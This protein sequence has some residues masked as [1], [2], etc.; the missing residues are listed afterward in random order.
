M[1]QGSQDLDNQL[2]DFAD[3]TFSILV[4]DVVVV[5]V[6]VVFFG[7]RERFGDA[8]H[9]DN[10][11]ELRRNFVELKFVEIVGVSNKWVER[12]AAAAELL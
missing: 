4:V 10:L 8:L 5:V 3:Y 9:V 11:F 2:L 1:L 6:V 12:L 7:W